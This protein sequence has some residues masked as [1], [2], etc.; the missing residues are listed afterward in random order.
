MGGINNV[1]PGLQNARTNV[2]LSPAMPSHF[3]RRR[4]TLSV[5][6]ALAAT[7]LPAQSAHINLADVDHDRILSEAALAFTAHPTSTM[8]VSAAIA[9]LT[10]AFILTKEDRYATAAHSHITSWLPKPISTEEHPPSVVD[11]VPVA[12]LARATSFLIDSPVD[13]APLNIWLADLLIWLITARDPVIVRDTKDHSASAWLLITSAIA[14]SQ[15]DEKTLIFCRHL[16]R[17]PTLRNQINEAGR[18]PQELATPN[19]FRNTLFNFDLLCGACQLLDTPLDPLWNYELIDGVSLRTV[20][21]YLFPILQDR[22]KWP[23]VSDADHFRDLPGRRPG[24]LFAGRAYGRPEYVE[25]WRSTPPTIPTAIAASFPIRQ[26]LLWTT[27]A[28]HGL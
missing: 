24:L 6:A 12:E 26:P 22:N 10:A 21:A 1:K 23:G 18:F 3:T 20:A 9:V 28:A 14:R 27:R 13:L 16:F 4:F 11:L 17:K 8:D 2:L 15:R 7:Q 5:A 19:P 25:L